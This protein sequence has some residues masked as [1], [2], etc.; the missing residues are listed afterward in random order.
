MEQAVPVLLK[1]WYLSIGFVKRS[2]DFKHFKYA[3]QR[4]KQNN[5]EA[6]RILTPPVPSAQ[7]NEELD[8]L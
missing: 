1:H 5:E 2:E 7:V 6:N 4:A 3:L 8:M